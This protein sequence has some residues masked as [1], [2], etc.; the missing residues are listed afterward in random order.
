MDGV[1]ASNTRQ[2]CGA[3]SVGRLAALVM[4]LTQSLFDPTELRLVCYVDDPLAA[5]RGTPAERRLY[6]AIPVSAWEAIGFKLAYA[7]GPP[8][9][10]VTWI[11]APL[12]IDTKGVTAVVKVSIVEDIL[13]DL[14]RIMAQTSHRKKSSA[15]SS[16]S[17]AMHQLHRRNAAFSSSS[18]GSLGCS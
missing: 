15:R 14:V 6:A 18:M 13:V 2:P 16:A 3:N 9:R 10:N 17:S 4:R 11:G 7:K 5:I 1:P 8:D 12:T